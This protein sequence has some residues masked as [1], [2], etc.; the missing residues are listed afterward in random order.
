MFLELIY[1]KERRKPPYEEAK[2]SRNL[3]QEKFKSLESRR[4]EK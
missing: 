4:L 2:E 3:V 1:E